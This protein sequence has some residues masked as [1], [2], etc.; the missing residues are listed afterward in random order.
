MEVGAK[1]FVIGL[2]APVVT[3]TVD[4]EE[5]ESVYLVTS[6]QGGAEHRTS[7]D[8]DLTLEVTI[9]NPGNEPI[10][11]TRIA[12]IPRFE[13]AEI[14]EGEDWK[15]WRPMTLVVPSCDAGTRV[16]ATVSCGDAKAWA[17]LRYHKFPDDEEENKK[18]E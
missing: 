3:A 11:E 10:T 17:S 1:P 9:Q 18:A 7:G 5:D 8:L 14:E 2:L 13:D 15:I 6:I 16:F 4:G 12:K